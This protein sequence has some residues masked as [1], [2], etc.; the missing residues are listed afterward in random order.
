MQINKV[1]LDRLCN[2]TDLGQRLAYAANELLENVKQG[3]DVSL[4]SGGIFCF[5]YDSDAHEEGDYIPF[6]T[7]TLEPYFKPKGN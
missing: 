5:S 4:E 2:N 3:V 7:I 1:A 6:V